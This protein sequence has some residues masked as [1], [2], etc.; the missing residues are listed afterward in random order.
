M[1]PKLK[2]EKDTVT[3][4]IFKNAHEFWSTIPTKYTRRKDLADSIETFWQ[5]LLVGVGGQRAVRVALHSLWPAGKADGQEHMVFGGRTEHGA[6][7]ALRWVSIS[8]HPL[9]Q[10][11]NSLQTKVHFVLWTVAALIVTAWLSLKIILCSLYE[12]KCLI[13][14]LP[15]THLHSEQVRGVAKYLILQSSH[16]LI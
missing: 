11:L 13:E 6:S 16:S 4:S 7:P 14:L 5:E 9:R 12:G 3:T 15:Q 10:P 1:K 8:L 2:W